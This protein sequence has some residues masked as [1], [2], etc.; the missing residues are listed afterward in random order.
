MTVVQDLQ[1]SKSVLIYIYKI[2]FHI[3]SIFSSP[4]YRFPFHFA[5]NCTVFYRNNCRLF[6]DPL[7]A[8]NPINPCFTNFKIK[9]YV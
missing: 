8:R 2:Y 9:V 7:Y 5:C 1:K 6:N 4:N 3:L